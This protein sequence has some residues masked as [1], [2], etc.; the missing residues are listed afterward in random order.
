VKQLHRGQSQITYMTPAES[1]STVGTRVI[2][3][4]SDRYGVKDVLDLYREVVIA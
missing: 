2:G 4:Q 3:G 1:G